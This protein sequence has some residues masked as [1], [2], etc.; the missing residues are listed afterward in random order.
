MYPSNTDIGEGMNTLIQERHSHSENCLTVKMSRRTQKLEIYHANEG[1]GLALFITDQKHIFASEV[2]KKFGVTLR[3]RGPLK[4]EF[5]YDIVCIHCLMIYKD[6][7][8]YEI[9]SDTTTPLLCCFP[10]ISKLKAGDIITTGH[11]MYYQ[12]FINL[13]F[14]PLLKDSFHSIHIEFKGTSVE[15]YP[16]YLSPSIDL[17]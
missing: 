3:G 16:F 15:T 4:R 7:I 17:R 2:R 5:A 14:R 12:T 6:F 9:I 13:Q 11:Y 1:S 8:E 10:V